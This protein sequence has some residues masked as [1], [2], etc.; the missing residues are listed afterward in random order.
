LLSAGRIRKEILQTIAENCSAS[1]RTVD[2]WIKEAAPIVAERKAEAER[3]RAKENEALVIESA[4]RLNITQERIAEQYAKTAF[5]DPVA[6]MKG[7]LASTPDK[8]DPAKIDEATLTYGRLLG[9]KASDV[10]KA[11]DSL[12]KMYGY[13]APEKQQVDLTSNGQTINNTFVIKRRSDRDNPGD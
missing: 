12:C 6:E 8:G 9:V 13:N 3:I 7:L 10:N 4:Q 1:E 2:N 11:L 5:Y